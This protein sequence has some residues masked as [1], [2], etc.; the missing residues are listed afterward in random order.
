M[1]SG[2]KSTLTDMRLK[3]WMVGG[4]QFVKELLHSCVTCHRYQGKPYSAPQ[5]PPFLEFRVKDAPPFSSLV[6]TLLAPYL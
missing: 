6:W 4:R 3:Y 5:A 1:H 2:V